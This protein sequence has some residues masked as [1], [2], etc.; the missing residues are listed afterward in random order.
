M[1]WWYDGSFEGFLS[2]VHESYLRRVIPDSI[3]R[4][5]STASLLDEVDDIRTD[6]QV[7]AKVFDS[8]RKTFSQTVSERIAHVFLC[9]DEPFERDLLLYIRLGFKS[10]SF[11][12]DLAHPVVFAIHGYERRVLSTRHRMEGF[13]RFEELEDGTL[14]A[15]IT[16]PRN[17]LMLLGGHF[18]KRMCGT[19]FIIHDLK[20][21]LAMTYS[22]GI[23]GIHTV[24][25]ADIPDLS[26]DELKFQRLWKTFFDHVAIESRTNHHLQRSQVP[27]LYRKY[28]SEFDRGDG[29]L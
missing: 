20:R 13:I 6:Y 25:S 7:A 14:Y 28:M 18:T 22:G 5:R 3:V 27:L 21:S 11:L 24:A 29:T 16:P 23:I 1:L 15:R 2:L 12:N 4:Y 26:A 17:V 8:M 9:D 19:P 10:E